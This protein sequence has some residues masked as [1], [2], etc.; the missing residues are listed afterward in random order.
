MKSGKVDLVIA[1]ADRIAANGDTAN[2]IGTYMLAVLAKAHGLPFTIAAPTS[3]LD[4]TLPNGEAIPIEERHSSELT[5]AE[6]AAIAPE[7][8]PVFN[9]AFDVTP[10]TMIDA[11]VT[12]AGVH[13]GPYAFLTDASLSAL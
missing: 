5:H 6:G 7:G 9:P 12:E 3:T 8:T 13:R 4:A 2:K 11:I 1:G 10:G